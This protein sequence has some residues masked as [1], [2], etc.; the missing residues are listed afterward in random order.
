MS[1]NNQDDD[2]GGFEEAVDPVKG[3]S[4]FSQVN[5]NNNN[6]TATSKKPTDLPDWLLPEQTNNRPP[7]AAYETNVN[8]LIKSLQDE[9]SM[10]KEQLIDHQTSYLQLQTQHRQE[11]EEKT[12]AFDHSISIVYKECQNMMREQREAINKDMRVALEQ[13]KAEHER[14]LNEKIREMSEKFENRLLAFQENLIKHYESEF[15]DVEVKVRKTMS[16]I[17]CDEQSK[18]MQTVKQ[19]IERLERDLRAEIEKHMQSYF[20]SQSEVFKESIKSGIAQEHLI[21]KDMINSKLEK[22]FKA[23]EEKRRKTNLIFARHMVS[24][25][26]INSLH[27]AY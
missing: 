18:E 25:L 4:S 19:S 11:V 16:G 5:S 17:I 26:R 9:L 20:M 14:R 15:E 1:T 24:K 8:Q 10:A 12:L 22:L 3:T 2:F 6:N 27:C 13:H 7:T 23:S 21:H